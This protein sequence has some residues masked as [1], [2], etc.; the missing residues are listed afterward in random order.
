MVDAPRSQHRFHVLLG[1][2]LGQ[3][4]RSKDAL[5]VVCTAMVMPM[6]MILSDIPQMVHDKRRKE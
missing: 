3:A 5:A 1:H 2:V 4:H 6:S